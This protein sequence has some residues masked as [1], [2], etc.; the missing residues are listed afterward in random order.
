MEEARTACNRSLGSRPE[1]LERCSKALLVRGGAL[2]A[3]LVTV[4]TAADTISTA[5]LYASLQVFAEKPVPKSLRTNTT[6]TGYWLLKWVL[7]HAKE[8]PVQG[9]G[10]VVV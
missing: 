10:A 6:G 2:F 5:E 8:L 3:E 7:A 9:I 1:L 4:I